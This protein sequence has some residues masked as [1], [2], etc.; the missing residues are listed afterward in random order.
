MNN[1]LMIPHGTVR[2][3]IRIFRRASP[4]GTRFR[5]EKKAA[6]PAG[7]GGFGKPFQDTQARFLKAAQYMRTRTTPA[8]V[9]PTVAA[10]RFL[11]MFSIV[12]TSSGTPSGA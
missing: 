7:D 3:E 11:T 9:L 5:P 2:A 1:L 12:I 8:M 4:C 10:E 6:V